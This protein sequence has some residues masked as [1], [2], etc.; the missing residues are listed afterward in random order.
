LNASDGFPVG[1]AEVGPKCEAYLE[2]QVVREDVEKCTCN[3]GMMFYLAEAGLYVIGMDDDVIRG[4]RD[5]EV[6]RCTP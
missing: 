2:E 3:I 6:V 4:V 5:P 1:W